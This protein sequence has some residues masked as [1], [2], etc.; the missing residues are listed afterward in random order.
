MALSDYHLWQLPERS[1]PE[2]EES[3]G[4][5]ELENDLGNGYYSQVLYGSNTGL[6]RWRL[7]L[8]TLADTSVLPNTVV[9]ISGAA[10]SREEYLWELFCET[11][12][13]GQPFAFQSHR[14]GQYYLVR[15]ADKEL[16]YQKMRVKL[17][18]SGIELKQVRVDG[19]T[20]FDPANISQTWSGYD[21][22]DYPAFTGGWPGTDGS[23]E[24]FP[25]GTD[26]INAISGTRDI[27]RFSNTTNNGV[28]SSGGSNVTIRDIIILMK[29]RE[30]TWSNNG[31]VVTGALAPN[32]AALVGS[33]TTTK[34]FNL[35][36]GSGYTYKLDGVEYAESDQ[37]APMN[38]WGVVHARFNAGGVGVPITNLQVGADR[39]FVGRFSEIDIAY[40]IISDSLFPTSALREID[41]HLAIIRAGLV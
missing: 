1:S 34:F 5:T 4:F 16:T 12:V 30:A 31:G 41:E 14:N 36:F 35:G 15:F 18:S 23:N 13:T 17:Y 25:L 11:K 10:V 26:V 8:P 38:T 33:A 27:V 40:L 7:R 24:L 32:N 6:R 20:V 3:I 21:P 28:L 22:N 39:D 19:Q 9:G 29:V 37:Q 2:P